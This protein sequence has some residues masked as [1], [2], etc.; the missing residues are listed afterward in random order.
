M[1]PICEYYNECKIINN[2]LC[3]IYA[4]ITMDVKQSITIYDTYM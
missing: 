2:Y 1:R 3:D 4:N